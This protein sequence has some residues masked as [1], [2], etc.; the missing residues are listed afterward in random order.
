VWVWVWVWV[1]VGVGGGWVGGIGLEFAELCRACARRLAS[2]APWRR[3]E[4]PAQA[5]PATCARAAAA[6]RWCAS[7]PTTREPTFTLATHTGA[8]AWR[9]DAHKVSRL[10]C[11]HGSHHAAATSYA[12]AT[13][14]PLRPPCHT[15]TCTCTHTYTHKHT[16]ATPR[17]AHQGP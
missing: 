9:G 17:T 8:L 15:H 5:T 2:S 11:V 7:G 1:G 6:R 16:C 10:G 14:C 3:V 13:S 4:R 12:H